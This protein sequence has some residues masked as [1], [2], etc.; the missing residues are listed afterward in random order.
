[1]VPNIE[2]VNVEAVNAIISGLN[3]D[4]LRIF[5]NIKDMLTARKNNVAGEPRGDSFLA[6]VGPV[7]AI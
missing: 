6:L 3:T 4:Q 2:N 5:N 7:S 1:M